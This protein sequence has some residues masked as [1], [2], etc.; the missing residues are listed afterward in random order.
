MALLKNPVVAASSELYVRLH[1]VLD[2]E[3]Y[4]NLKAA[5]T[6]AGLGPRTSLAKGATGD[7]SVNTVSL[8][9]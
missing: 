5:A 3:E 1:E 4:E 9:N 8:R 6:R 2:R 7:Q